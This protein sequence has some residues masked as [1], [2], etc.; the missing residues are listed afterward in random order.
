[1]PHPLALPEP[2]RTAVV[3]HGGGVRLA[4]KLN[5]SYMTLYRWAHSLHPP[6]GVNLDRI[7]EVCPEVLDADA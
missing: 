4:R 3:K 2:W 5:V 1:M 6:T 7:K